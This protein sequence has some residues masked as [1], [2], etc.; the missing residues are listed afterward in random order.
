MYRFTP[1]LSK[2]TASGETNKPLLSTPVEGQVWFNTTQGRPFVYDG[3][4]W[5]PLET[6]GD[7]AVNWGTICD[8]DQLPLPVAED[9]Y[10]FSYSEC[11]WI[12][13]PRG[14]DYEFDSII[15]ET[16][17][18]A[19]VEI[20]YGNEG[21]DV[22]RSGTANY[23]IVG[24]RGNQNIGRLNPCP[25]PSPTPSPEVMSPSP[26]PTQTAT[27]TQTPAPGVS[28]T[29]TPT[30]AP[31]PTPSAEPPSNPFGVSM[32][33]TNGSASRSVTVSGC[34]GAPYQ[35]IFN[36]SAVPQNGVP[37]YSYS[38]SV[39]VVYNFQG[40]PGVIASISGSGNSASATLQHGCINGQNTTVAMDVR[41]DVTQGNGQTSAHIL[42]VSFTVNS[43]LVSVTPTPAPTFSATPQATPVASVTPSPTTTP[44]ASITPTP[45]PVPMTLPGGTNTSFFDSCFAD[46]IDGLDGGPTSPCAPFVEITLPVQ[47][48]TPPYS[49][50]YSNTS[51]FLTT[52]GTYSLGMGIDNVDVTF[53]ESVTITDSMSATLV[54]PI[55]IRL[56]RNNNL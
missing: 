34:S 1:D 44:Q 12:V 26:T 43:N 4:G 40:V 2:V 50:S 6:F 3:L 29:P 46:A 48:G 16:D 47:G 49:Y 27:P 17:Q 33:V 56:V 14:S 37:P 51:G 25:P 10:V 36:I 7:I 23:F 38:W 18:N 28:V 19:V 13:S 42:T 52:P 41:V 53:G 24:I 22:V 32:T 45:S 9:G 55:T 20:K 30:R 5:V 21:T 8:G 31:T 35:Q 39:P 54:V 15:C 11:A